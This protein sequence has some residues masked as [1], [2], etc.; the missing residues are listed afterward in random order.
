M[1]KLLLV[2]T[3]LICGILLLVLPEDKLVNKEK[4]KPNQDP[5]QAVK[6]TRNSGIIFIIIAI[7]FAIIM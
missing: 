5:I 7:V 1:I 2:G 3:M 6:Q 4:L